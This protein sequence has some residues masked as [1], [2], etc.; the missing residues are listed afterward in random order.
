MSDPAAPNAPATLAQRRIAGR[1][2]WSGPVLI[3][4]ARS[5]FAVAA[6]GLVA[7]GLAARGSA[8]PWREA[9]AWLPVYGTLIDLGCLLL[10]A[11]LTRREGIRLRD[12]LGFAR[13]RLGRDL[14]LALALVPPSLVFIVAGN[15]GASLLVFGRP[16]AA[17]L[18]SP[19]P[20]WAALYAVLVF[21]FIWGLVEQTTYNGYAVPRLTTLFGRTA[22]AV[23]L[24]A[25]F[26]S[27]QHAFMPLTFDPQFMLYRA[28]SPIPHSLFVIL[29]WLR[30]RR[31]LPLAL[32]HGLMDGGAAFA[33]TLLPLLG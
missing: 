5:V 3:L 18:F 11:R 26:W 16:E 15:A 27:V 22:P 6:Q 23:A 12:L 10:L 29:V 1:L 33:G 32:A 25:F 31:I 28:L 9:E 30:L 2:G 13:G 17:M 14:L 19:L 4:F 21:P 20:L 7:A 24:V 8:A